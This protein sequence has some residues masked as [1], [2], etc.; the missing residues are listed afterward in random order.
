[1]ETSIC[2]EPIQS[3]RNSEWLGEV[4]RWDLIRYNEHRDLYMLWC[5][6]HSMEEIAESYS[7]HPKTVRNRIDLFFHHAKSRLRF[8]RKMRSIGLELKEP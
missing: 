8:E 1:M 7:L 5:S 6:G 2:I 4:S 3:D